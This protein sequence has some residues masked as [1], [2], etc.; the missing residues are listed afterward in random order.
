M[1]TKLFVYRSIFIFL[2]SYAIL[3]IF[4]Y[5]VNP[6][7]KFKNSITDKKFV[8]TKEYSRIQ[9][10]KLRNDN[11]ILIFGTSQSHMIS[12]KMMKN[13]TLNFHNLYAE[14]GDILNFLLH[15]DNKQIKNIAKI[16]YLIDLRAGASRIDKNLINYSEVKDM[17][18][19]LTNSMLINLFQDVKKNIFKKYDSYLV[20]D[21]SIFYLNPSKHIK[22]INQLYNQEPSLPYDDRLIHDIVKIDKFS[23]Q[24][25]ID[26]KY[27]TP[28]VNE[29]YF[30]SINFNKLSTFYK[31]LLEYNIKDL[32]LFYYIN[33]Y[34]NLKNSKGEYVAFVEK[35]HLNQ[36]YVSMWL[37]KYILKKSEFNINNKEELLNYINNVKS[38]Q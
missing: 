37:H 30:K 15:L 19:A 13:N 4:Y 34:S 21:G 12:T 3:F 27:I 36:K 7:Q 33:G 20:E 11:Y 26:I 16:I 28:V 32:N 5:I 18:I 17:S 35:D 2:L 14:P 10:D 8:N 29:K 25:D 9:F 24:H 22:S 6:E 38:I 31:K 1:K 23:K